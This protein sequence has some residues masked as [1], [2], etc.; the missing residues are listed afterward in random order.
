MSICYCKKLPL[1]LSIVCTIMYLSSGGQLQASLLNTNRKLG[2]SGSIRALDAPKLALSRNN[3]VWH[4]YLH[5]ISRMRKPKS[6]PN[7]RPLSES[8][9]DANRGNGHDYSDNCQC[10]S[11]GG[12]SPTGCDVQ[13]KEVI[14]QDY[15]G[16]T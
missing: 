4:K 11:K 13:P 7:V 10:S 9:K 14:G 1:N 5:G 3:N 12:C 15:I 8:L 6:R 2:G 16:N